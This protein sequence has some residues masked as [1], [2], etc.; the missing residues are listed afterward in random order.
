MQA[1]FTLQKRWKQL[2]EV[3]LQTALLVAGGL[4]LFWWIVGITL[5]GSLGIAYDDL[6]IDQ[7]VHFVE[8]GHHLRDPYV[9]PGFV[10]PPW[11]A[12]LLFPFSWMPVAL[13]VLIQ[14]ELYFLFLTL[15]IFRFG[16]DLRGGLLTLTSYM[17]FDLSMETSIDWVPYAGLLVPAFFSGP[18]LL[19]KP[20]IAL[21]AWIGYR[22]SQLIRALLGT[23]LILLISYLI[24]GFWLPDMWEAVQKYTLPDAYYGQFNLAPIT[25]LPMPLSILIGLGLAGRAFWRKDV[26]LGIFAWLFFVPYIPFYS[27]ILYFA[28]MTI[29]L[30]LLAKIIYGC[31][32]LIYGG[33]IVLALIL[34]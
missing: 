14:L 11:V 21:G 28:L 9:M 26:I 7:R 27:L 19:T 2:Q 31:T 30:P 20:Q 18:L 25:L 5:S 10:Y 13:A 8:A 4:A 3:R 1:I 23:I 12:V 6:W 22:P 32:W 24:W 17:V 16:G 29:R 15:I 33:I 34:R